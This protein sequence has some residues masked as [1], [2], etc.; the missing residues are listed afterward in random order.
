VFEYKDSASNPYMIDGRTIHL[1][2]ESD[3]SD[4]GL[5]LGRDHGIILMGPEAVKVACKLLSK[6]DGTKPMP[7]QLKMAC[8]ILE[9][10]VE[11]F[12]TSRCAL[13]QQSLTATWFSVHTR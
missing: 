2:F 11:V 4:K 9:L 5:C 12:K 7:L 8:H 3:Y 10:F 13:L 6:Y 1:D